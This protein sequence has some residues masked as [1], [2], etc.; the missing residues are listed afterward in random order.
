[1]TPHSAQGISVSIGRLI[2]PVLGLFLAASLVPS[3]ALAA[4]YAL[5]IGIG[6][7]DQ[8]GDLVN[9]VPD[10]EALRAELVGHGFLAQALPNPTREEL[11]KLLRSYFGREYGPKDQLLIVFAG[12]GKYDLVTRV[13]YLAA[14]D[15]ANWARDE[16][17]T[18]LISYPWL[19]ALLD[20]IECPNIL[21]VVDACFSGSLEN[22]S[23]AAEHA[24]TTVSGTPS[25]RASVVRRFLTSGGVEYVPDGRPGHHTPFMRQLLDGL[26][27]NAIGER[28]ALKDLQKRFMSRVETK[29]RWGRFGRDAGAG[30]IVFVRQKETRSTAPAKPRPASQT[31]QGTSSAKTD[32]VAAPVGEARLRARPAEVTEQ[33]L[34]RIYQSKNLCDRTW[35]PRNDFPNQFW[36]QDRDLWQVVVD[37]E[38]DLM[39]Q[40]SGSSERL[41]RAEVDGYIRQLNTSRHAGFGNWRLPT[42]EELASLVEQMPAIDLYISQNFD[43]EQETC[44]SADRDAREGDPYYV[45]F[46]TGRTSLEYKGRRH[47]VRAVRSQ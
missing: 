9:P 22:E 29:P 28:L 39:W 24:S 26:R 20:N 35:N 45:S 18:T 30:D 46:N 27:S 7:Y 15:S 33:Q 34:K 37:L 8:L 16:S 25:K 21:L 40:Q 2:L 4:D 14:K 10:V 32:P 11:M 42:L 47:F 1:M 36:I 6:K 41:S 19:L 12:H 3:R 23:K 43:V 17:Y 38:S 13:G 44:W 31:S 5:L